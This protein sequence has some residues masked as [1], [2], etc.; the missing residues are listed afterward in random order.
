M[1][2]DLAACWDRCVTSVRDIDAR[3]SDITQIEEGVYQGGTIVTRPSYEF[4]RVGA[5]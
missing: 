3:F 1:L 5:M 2:Y 4:V